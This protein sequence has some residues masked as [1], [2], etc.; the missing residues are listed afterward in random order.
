MKDDDLEY[1]SIGDSDQSED[2]LLFYTP[3]FV[4][5]I[6]DIDI[7]RKIRSKYPKITDKNETDK[8][9]RQEFL[10]M[11]EDKEFINGILNQYNLKLYDLFLIFKQHYTYLFNT[12]NYIK[13]VQRVID[14]VGYLKSK[15]EQEQIE[16]AKE[17]KK[18]GRKRKTEVQ[19]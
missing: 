19:S 4:D 2:N 17:K 15:E 1:Y 7:L 10:K 13:N 14:E 11:L 8:V 5:S 16:K 6:D 9:S 12:S 18:R 3:K